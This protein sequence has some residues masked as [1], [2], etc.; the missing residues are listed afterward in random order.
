MKQSFMATALG[1]LRAMGNEGG[2][3]IVD[4]VWDEMPDVEVG[5]KRVMGAAMRTAQGHG[6]IRPTGTFRKSLQPQ[7][8]GNMRQVWEFV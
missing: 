4:D 2:K 6:W 1:V 5:D 7:C 3:F 8:H